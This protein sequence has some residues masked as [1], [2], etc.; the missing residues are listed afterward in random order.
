MDAVSFVM[1]LLA[2]FTMNSPS[3]TRNAKSQKGSLLFAGAL[4]RGGSL[5]VDS[6]VGVGEAIQK[7][8]VFSQ[9]S[10]VKV[11]SSA[12]DKGCI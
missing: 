10:D 11:A 2:L 3:D 12:A 9:T 8:R 1:P 6:D 5:N 7:R 4:I